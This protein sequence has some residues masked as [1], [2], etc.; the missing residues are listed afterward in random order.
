MT[1]NINT[2]PVGLLAGKV[3][4][5]TGASR[6]IGAAAVRLFAAEGASVVL[7]ARGTEALDRIADEIRETGGTADALALDLADPSSIRA[8]VGSV[9]KLH[10][11]L[12]GAFNNG[13]AP[14]Q[15]FGPADTTT[16]HDIDEQ[17]TVNFR[18][19]WIA[20]N[21]EA[22]LMRSNGGG[23]IVNTSS[24]GSRRASPALPAY[25]AMKR[26][27]NSLTETAA[28][29]WAAG[30]IRV[31]A[32]TPGA[33]ATEMMDIW[34]EA[35]PGTLAATAASVPLGR[36]GE[37]R[38]IAEVAAWLLSDRASYVTGAIVPVDGGAGA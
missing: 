9:E 35:A 18:A 24:I 15:Q 13:A 4:L 28:V 8:V 6:G 7:A 20:M 11:R 1:N 34:E 22:A 16:D 14:Q 19:H 3:I 5:I 12:D 23:A 31:N 36:L 10:G 37:P 25:G 27:L 29:S 2:T 38:E 21:A 30:G 17:F 33:T 26:A 32:I